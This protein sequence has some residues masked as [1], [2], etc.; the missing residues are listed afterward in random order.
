VHNG[1]WCWLVRGGSGVVVVF[2]GGG[3]VVWGLGGV[4]WGRGVS[5]RGMPG[6]TAGYGGVRVLRRGD[7]DGRVRRRVKSEQI[8]R[9]DCGWGG[10]G[11][12]EG[13]KVGG[14]GVLQ[15]GANRWGR[16]EEK[17]MKGPG[18]KVSRGGGMVEESDG[19]GDYSAERRCRE[20][21]GGRGG[22]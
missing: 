4:V 10:G 5:G 2:G 8:G 1:G 21:L 13:C 19:G 9:Y 7:R 18:I 15:D 12:D 16:G 22:T 6:G 11:E 3:C 20:G 14:G 17:K